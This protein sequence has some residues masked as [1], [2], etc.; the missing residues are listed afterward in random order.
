MAQCRRAHGT[1]S[2]RNEQLEDTYPSLNQ[3]MS[4]YLS[5]VVMQLMFCLNYMFKCSKGIIG[6]IV[7]Y[8][9][10]LRQLSLNVV[11]PPC[12]VQPVRMMRSGMPWTNMPSTTRVTEHAFD[13]RRGLGSAFQSIRHQPHFGIKRPKITQEQTQIAQLVLQVC[14]HCDP[15]SFASWTEGMSEAVPPLPLVLSAAGVNCGKFVWR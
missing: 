13:F 14:S 7:P 5:H 6:S 8:H 11:I 1:K 4:I 10:P 12:S 3:V 9:L 15:P 2:F